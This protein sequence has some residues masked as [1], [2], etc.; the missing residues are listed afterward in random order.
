M[1]PLATVIVVEGKSPIGTGPELIA[2]DPM[3]CED[4]A[5]PAIDIAQ[6]PDDAGTWTIEHQMVQLA[7]MVIVEG[8]SLVAR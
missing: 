5:E 4:G 8:E 7:G 1:I 2:A 3:A 6:D